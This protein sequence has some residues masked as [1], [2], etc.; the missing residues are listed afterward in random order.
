MRK[1]GRT[2]VGL[3][4]EFSKIEIALGIAYIEFAPVS[5]LT[6]FVLNSIRTRSRLDK[7]LIDC[8]RYRI[9]ERAGRTV[10]R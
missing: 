2:L 1:D 10:S 5:I 3:L 8:R 7:T 4:H 6:G 9:R